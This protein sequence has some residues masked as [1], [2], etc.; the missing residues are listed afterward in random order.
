MTVVGEQLCHN[1]PTANCCGMGWDMA[2]NKKIKNSS[3]RSLPSSAIKAMVQFGGPLP[4][5]CCRFASF[6]KNLFFDLIS[7]KKP[8][9]IAKNARHAPRSMGCSWTTKQC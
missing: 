7:S 1:G 5:F 9:K 2:Q 4:E 3:I 8:E 6:K